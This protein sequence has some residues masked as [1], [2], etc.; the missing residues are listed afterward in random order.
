M[1]GTGLYAMTDEGVL[2]A[3]LGSRKLRLLLQC[4]FM[5]QPQ[6]VS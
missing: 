6:H 5:A 4:E 3:P 2:G 1:V